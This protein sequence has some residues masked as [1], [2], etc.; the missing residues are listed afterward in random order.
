MPRE[1]NPTTS[2]KILFLLLIHYNFT[3]IFYIF[4][5]LLHKQE[6]INTMG[7]KN[8]PHTIKGGSVVVVR[9]RALVDGVVVAKGGRQRR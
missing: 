8:H 9:R 1:K 7:K 3:V 2:S 5:F 6:G 4:I